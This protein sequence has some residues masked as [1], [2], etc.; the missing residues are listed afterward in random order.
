MFLH[1]YG[2]FSLLSADIFFPLSLLHFKI[3]MI[4]FIFML[5]ILLLLSWVMILSIFWRRWDFLVVFEGLF[6]ENTWEESYYIY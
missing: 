6:L 4:F 3:I 1:Q 2:V 5:L